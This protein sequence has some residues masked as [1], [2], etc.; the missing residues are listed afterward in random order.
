MTPTEPVGYP[1]PAVVR[2]SGLVTALPMMTGFL[3]VEHVVE[4]LV[5]DEQRSGEH[6]GDLGVV[7]HLGA[8]LR[9]VLLGDHL[10]RDEFTGATAETAEFGVDVLDGGL[11]PTVFSGNTASWLT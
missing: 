7:E 9:A 8:A 10:A 1:T 3:P 2:K 6:E 5:A 4:L 11:M